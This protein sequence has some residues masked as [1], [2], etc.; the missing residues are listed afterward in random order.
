MKVTIRCPVC[1]VLN[2]VDCITSNVSDNPVLT[3]ESEAIYDSTEFEC[4]KCKKEVRVQISVEL[5]E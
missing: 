2:V 1:G 5:F 4:P 3:I